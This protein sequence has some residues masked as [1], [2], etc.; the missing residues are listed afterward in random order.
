MNSPDENNPNETSKPG[1]NMKPYRNS[2]KDSIYVNEMLA[3]VNAVASAYFMSA[4]FD[5]S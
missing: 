2:I 5:R 3:W 4:L 1:F